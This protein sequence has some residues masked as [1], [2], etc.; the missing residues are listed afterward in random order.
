MFLRDKA[1]TLVELL[2]VIAIIA[3]LMGILIPA[4]DSARSQGKAVVCKSN[5]S[6]LVLANTGYATENDGYYVLAAKDMWNNSGLH[7]WHGVRKM[8]WINHLTR[9]KDLW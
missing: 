3:L 9:S 7:R 6:Q 1:F 4:L 8:L 2:V 5:L